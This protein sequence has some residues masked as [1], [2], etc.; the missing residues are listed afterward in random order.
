MV[1]RALTATCL[2]L[3]LACT[4]AADPRNRVSAEGFSGVRVGMTVEEAS[5]AYGSP[6]N[7]AVSIADDETSCYYVFPRGAVGPVSFMIVDGRVARVDIDHPGPVTEAE[8]GVGSLESEVQSAYAGRIKVSPHKYAGPEG[9]YLT[10]EQGDFAIIFE[11]DGTQVTSYRA[12]KLP[13][14]AWVERCS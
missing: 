14:V 11:T 1:A 3:G 12:G 9:H 10:V 8:V 7:S 6:L 4:T 5:K 13:E 2:S